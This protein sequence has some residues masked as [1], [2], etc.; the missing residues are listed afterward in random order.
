MLRMKRFLLVQIMKVILCGGKP[1]DT[2]F[3]C[4]IDAGIFEQDNSMRIC[5]ILR[6]E[7]GH[8]VASSTV[9]I[10]GIF[11]VKE[12]EGTGLV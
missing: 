6:D 8:F 3:K 12:T 2:T 9:K 10:L 11:Q 7:A 5:M 1:S 4:N